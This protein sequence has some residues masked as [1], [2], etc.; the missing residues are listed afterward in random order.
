M[1]KRE[2]NLWKVSNYDI[3]IFFLILG[4]LMGQIFGKYHE[5]G[6]NPIYIEKIRYISKK[7]I[8]LIFS[9]KNRFFANPGYDCMSEKFTLRQK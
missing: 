9:R 7:L 4:G 6:K 2:E 3:Y 1:K 5:L 8:F